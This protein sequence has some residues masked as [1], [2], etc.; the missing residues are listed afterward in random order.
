MKIIN[1]KLKESIILFREYQ[2]DKDRVKEKDE[3]N[4]IS[5]SLGIKKGL[6]RALANYS[7]YDKFVLVEWKGKK[8]MGD[9]QKKVSNNFIDSDD[10]YRVLE[11]ILNEITVEK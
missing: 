1:E 9:Y 3:I 5:S 4:F 6:A 11:N 7:R 2:E 10:E 8:Y